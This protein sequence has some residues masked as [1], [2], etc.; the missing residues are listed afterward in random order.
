MN[1]K[2]DHKKNEKTVALE[3]RTKTGAR[4][5]SPSA[6]R[7]RDVIR[8]VYLEHMPG[9]GKALE[10]GSGSGEHAVH[11]AAALPKVEWNTSDLDPSSRQS[12]AA[13]IDYTKLENLKGPYVIDVTAAHWDV[14]NATPFDAVISINMIHIA[15]FAAARGVIS[16]AG[17]LLRAGGKLFFY[18]PFMRG[19]EHTASSN[20]DFDLSLKARDP[21][22]GVRDL[23]RDILPITEKVG[24]TLE[25][26][27]EMPANNL[28]V[29]FKK[30]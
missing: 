28:S 26:T 20:A 8:A 27:V 4:L 7:N 1:E 5:F 24:L 2:P 12:I 18:G 6:A 23:E 17:R 21:A 13:W 30:H 3:T 22:W 9:V 29:I 16:N 10:V 14:D 11:L 19:G 25:K 15:P